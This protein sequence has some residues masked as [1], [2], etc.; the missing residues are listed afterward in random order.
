MSK[1]CFLAALWDENERPGLLRTKDH[2]RFHH[3]VGP[4]Y[5]TPSA[6]RLEVVAEYGV[7][8]LSD[9][10]QV[11]AI[12]LKFEKDFP[13][14][15]GLEN[16]GGWLAPDGT[17]YACDPYRHISLAGRLAAVVYSSL[18]NGEQLLE[19]KGWIKVYRALVCAPGGD[20]ERGPTQDQ[21]DTLW[22]LHELAVPGSSRKQRILQAL[23]L[24]LG[25]D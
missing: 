23:N 9:D 8:N 2:L 3:G 5:F 7:V 24:F 17:F 16:R 15:P 10:E 6:A 12:C 1:W 20:C 11:D 22:D 4:S 21:L 14:C 19:R 18:E 25:R 13:P